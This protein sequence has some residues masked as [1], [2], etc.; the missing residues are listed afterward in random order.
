VV[1]ARAVADHPAASL[2]TNGAPNVPVA[3]GS[4][5]DGAV[6]TPSPVAP[7][8]SPGAAKPQ[9]VATQFA[10]AWLHHTGVTAK[11]WLASLTPYVTDRL[12][13]QLADADPQTV[14]ASRITGSIAIT[15]HAADWVEIAVPMDG[16]TVF[17]FVTDGIEAALDRAKSAARTGNVEIAGGASTINAYLDAGLV[18]ELH[19]HIAPVVLGEG[20]RLFAGVTGLRMQPVQVVGSP[21]ATHVKYRLR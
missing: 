8:T 12:A 9:K 13:G 15:P 14:P 16:G 2:I 19:M 4:P 18:D 1:I 6:T 21:G 10:T 11:D 17:H 3:S 5:D 7:L 20:E